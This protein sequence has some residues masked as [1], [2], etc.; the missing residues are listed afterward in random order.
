MHELL[1]RAIR[2]RRLLMFAY[3]DTI[4]IV[5]AH[6]YGEAANGNRLVNAWLRPGHSR[7]TPDGGWRNFQ[8]HDIENVQLLDETF[9]GPREGYAAHDRSLATVFA[10]LAVSPADATHAHA[11]EHGEYPEPPHAK[12]I[13]PRPPHKDEIGA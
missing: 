8:L 11:G 1:L 13:D 7:T 4:R 6:R 3:R 10:E 2:E 9:A 5:E 12:H